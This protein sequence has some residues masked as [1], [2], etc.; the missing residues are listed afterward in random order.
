M[1]LKLILRFYLLKLYF[2]YKVKFHSNIKLMSEKL[3]ALQPYI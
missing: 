2:F 3:R 1:E